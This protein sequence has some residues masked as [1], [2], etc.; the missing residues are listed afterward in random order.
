MNKLYIG[1][2][3][4]DVNEGSIRELFHEQTGA[5]PKS[6][7]LKK[8]G[9]AFVECADDLVISKAIEALNGHSFMGSQLL[10]EPQ[11][12][13]PQ[14]RR[15]RG[16]RVHVSNIPSHV[17]RED[18][19]DLLATFG[20]VQNL[21]LFPPSKPESQ[22]FRAQ[23]TYETPE[24]AQ[25]AVAQLRDYEYEGSVLRAEYAMDMSMRNGG[26]GGGGGRNNM[27]M[28]GNRPM[29]R[30]FQ[31]SGGQASPMRPSDFPLRILVLSDMVGAIIGRAGGTIRQITQQSRARVDVHR[32]ENAG[33][34]EK[35]I[36]IYGNPENCSTACQKIL[37]VMQQEA[38]NTNRGDVPLKILAHNNLI[39]RIIGKSGNTIKRIMEQTD[40]KITVSSL[41]DGSALH[42]ERVITIKG[43]PEGVCRAEQLVSAK[44]RQSYESDLAALAPQSLMFPGLHPMAMM[45]A[46]APPPPVHGPPARPPHYRG[47]G[48]GGPYPHPPTMGGGGYMGGATHG[49]M[50]GY[51]SPGHGV[52]RELV[53]LYIPNT[54]VGAIIGTGGSSIRDMIMLSG[55]SI[56]VAQPN[57]DDPAD[58]HERKVT[59]VGT[60]ECQWRA[61]SMIFNKV[62]YE[63]CMGNPDGTLRVEIYVP[64]NQVGRIIGKGGQTVRELQRLT[65]ALIKLPEESQNANTEETPV[66]LLGDF[67]ST[68]AAQRQIRALVNRNQ[69]VGGQGPYPMHPRMGPRRGGGGG[70][71]NSNRQQQQQQQPSPP[72]SSSSSQPPQPQAG[73]PPSN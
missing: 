71:S 28:G 13:A 61:Q 25:Q 59:I 58:A 43:K 9:Y 60:P 65:R 1:N 30:P 51:M 50:G 19:H 49:P 73:S 47:G 22:T 31:Y 68:H 6:V 45:S 20:T 8:G 23:V 27:R 72:S 46:Y 37:E 57:K 11:Q 14:N 53:C 55:A 16:N 32:K 12:S 34:L 56:K 40:T 54:A 64:S 18:V 35:V 62:C 67:F 44:L 52:D 7:L 15:S 26:G 36:T 21:E 24:Q 66:H 3:P 69:M 33:S 39:G 41:H 38:S 63:G 4:A 48:G 17:Q 10:V 2:L 5:V 70:G 42:L 29:F